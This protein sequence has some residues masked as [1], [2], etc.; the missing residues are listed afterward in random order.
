[1]V[2]AIYGDPPD[3]DNTMVNVGLRAASAPVR[4]TF[5]VHLEYCDWVV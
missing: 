2:T 4:S 3:A 1:L 5:A